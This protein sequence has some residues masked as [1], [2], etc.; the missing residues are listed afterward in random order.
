MLPPMSYLIVPDI[1]CCFHFTKS[2]NSLQLSLQTYFYQIENLLIKKIFSQ[3]DLLVREGGGYYKKNKIPF[4]TFRLNQCRKSFG[5]LALLCQCG[6]YVKILY[7]KSRMSSN[8]KKKN[9][10]RLPFKKKMSSFCQKIE[11]VLW[12]GS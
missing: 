4:K 7:K 5:D 2:W 9:W 1:C 11:V 3:E 10:V 12:N 6:M 8:Y